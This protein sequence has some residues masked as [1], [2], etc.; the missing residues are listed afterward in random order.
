M[1][2]PTFDVWCRRI[3]VDDG[4]LDCLSLSEDR[5]QLTTRPLVS[6]GPRSVILGPSSS[7]SESGGEETGGAAAEAVTEEPADVI[8][9]ANRFDTS[10]YLHRINIR[11][12]EG[13][14]MHDVWR[15]QGGPGAYISTT[16][17][18]FPNFF[19]VL[20]PNGVG[21]H[22]SV[23]LASENV[24][25]YVLPHFV[26]KVLCGAARTVEVK[27]EAERRYTADVQRRSRDKVWQ[28]CRGGYIADS[29]WNSAICP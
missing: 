23:I 29:G 3:I 13:K 26:A 9:L 12:G 19:M 18:G 7:K 6:V 2:T 4:W 28:G 27:E 21:G 11:N 25:G 16:V 8:V 1:L 22:S 10:T 5:F 24:A 15:A 14:S 17:H 20:G